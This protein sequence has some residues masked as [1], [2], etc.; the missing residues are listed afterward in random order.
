VVFFR[1]NYLTL[2][3]SKRYL[4][5]LIDR[6]DNRAFQG[7]LQMITTA[8]STTLVVNSA[9]M[10]EIKDSNPALADIVHQLR[11]VCESEDDAIRVSRQ[12]TKLLNGLRDELSLQFA[13]EEAYGYVEVSE[14]RHQELS[15]AVHH[16]K[17]E[18]RTLYVAVTE[19]AEAAEELQYRG[20][21]PAELRTLIEDTRM[22]DRQLRNHEKAEDELIDQSFDLR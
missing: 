14:S 21:E 6:L 13:L 17:L 16:A 19:L 2:P 12:L 18:H 15:E 7:R 22:F 4:G 20:V 5:S 10:Q 11:H 3:F 8:I 1:Q 9:F